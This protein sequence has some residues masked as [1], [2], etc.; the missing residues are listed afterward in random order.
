MRW[1]GGWGDVLAA[2]SFTRTSVTTVSCHQCFE[3]TDIL[4]GRGRQDETD[5]CSLYFYTVLQKT[6]L[7]NSKITLSDLNRF[8]FFHRYQQNEIGKKNRG[9]I[10]TRPKSLIHAIRPRC[11]SHVT[12]RDSCGKS[13]TNCRSIATTTSGLFGNCRQRLRRAPRTTWRPEAPRLLWQHIRRT[14]QSHSSP[15]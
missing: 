5:H 4:G 3:E 9:Q 11:K 7:W 13:R 6:G 12:Y 15:S 8:A 14:A 10:F 1:R 2:V